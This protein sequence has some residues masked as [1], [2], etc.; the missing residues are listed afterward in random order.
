MCLRPNCYHFLWLFLAEM[1]Q[2]QYLNINLVGNGIIYIQNIV[3]NNAATFS[4]LFD[5][6]IRAY[7]P[8]K[9]EEINKKIEE[10]EEWN[11]EWGIAESRNLNPYTYSKYDYNLSLYDPCYLKL[12]S[13]IEKD[14]IE[15]L[16]S[17][18]DTVKW[19]WQNGDEHMALNFGI[20][21]NNKS[22]FQPDFIVLFKDGKLGIFDTKA[23]GYNEDDNK[24]KSEALQ[25]YIKEENK[26]IFGGLII[27]EGQHFRINT[28]ENYAGFKENPD[29]WEY[30][31]ELI[32]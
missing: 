28:K 29:D 23:S 3:L 22:T 21:Y 9:D 16:E 10:I 15:Y 19:W 24:L 5:E 2:C 8:V 30:F 26:N 31:E 25:K 32:K 17:K 14:F 12:D 4:K 20:K 18:K 13:N 1:G 6:A 11:E 7:K 27:K